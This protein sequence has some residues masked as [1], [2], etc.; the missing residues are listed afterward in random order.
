MAKKRRTSVSN[1][2]SS[3]VSG[4]ASRVTVVIDQDTSDRFAKITTI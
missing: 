4:N 2:E 3:A 1:N